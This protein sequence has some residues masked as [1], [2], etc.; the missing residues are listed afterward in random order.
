MKIEINIPSPKFEIGE[1]V[2][3]TR[4]FNSHCEGETSVIIE[5]E[6]T[7]NSNYID[8]KYLLNGKAKVDGRWVYG[9]EGGCYAEAEQLKRVKAVKVSSL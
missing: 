1:T 3:I 4:H 9:L 8:G 6:F 2:T 5:R 7:F